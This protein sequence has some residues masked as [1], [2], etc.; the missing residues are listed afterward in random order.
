MPGMK[1]GLW[2]GNFP[3]TLSKIFVLNSTITVCHPLLFHTHCLTA[4]E[5]EFNV[6]R[7]MKKA[8]EYNLPPNFHFVY[9]VFI[10]VSPLSF[11]TTHIL[12]S[13]LAVS[14]HK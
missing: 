13:W 5:K 14:D 2:L 1:T 10:V 6:A 4:Q 7:D 12:H 11:S 9:L 8:T 3:Y